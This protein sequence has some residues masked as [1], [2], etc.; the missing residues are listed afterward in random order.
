MATAQNALGITYND[1]LAAINPPRKTPE[2]LYE[3]AL[4]EV[5]MAWREGQLTAAEADEILNEL[6]SARLQYE[7]RGVFSAVFSDD[8]DENGRRDDAASRRFS[9]I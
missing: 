7:L 6:L 5:V 1:L 2:E 4:D 9:L 8:D 3:L